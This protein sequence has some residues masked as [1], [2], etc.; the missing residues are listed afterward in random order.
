MTENICGFEKDDGE[1][2]KRPAGWGTPSQLGHCKDHAEEYRV[3]RK[4]TPDT[5][6]SLIGAAQRGAFKKH[7][8]QIAGITP[9]TLRNWL[10]QG[11]E[12]INTGLE[13]PLSEFY[14]R[15]HRARAAGA[16][17]QLSEA[18]AEFVLERSYGYTKSQDVNLGGQ[19][20]NPVQIEFAEEVIT[21]DW[22]GEE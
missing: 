17:E 22:S 9:Q 3:P 14:L 20:D 4:L 21:T 11:E 18:S 8:A 15:F 6:S 5:K 12:H 19:A 10:N 1:P 2:C 7:C 16:A 13:T